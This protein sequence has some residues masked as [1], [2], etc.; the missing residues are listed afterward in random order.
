M[1]KETVAI[2]AALIGAVVGSLG[3][4]IVADR[5]LRTR[6][7]RQTARDLVRLH[8]IQLEDAAESLLRRLENVKSRGEEK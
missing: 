5:L 2:V 6:E 4:Q 3:A 1:S 7:R 8:L